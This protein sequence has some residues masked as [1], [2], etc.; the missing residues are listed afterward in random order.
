MRSRSHQ[1][2]ARSTITISDYTA[3][4]SAAATKVPDN[5]TLLE[6]RNIGRRDAAAGKWLLHDVSFQVRSG[7]RVALI[8]PSGSGKTLL[9]RA[10]AALDPVE[11]GQLLWRGQP[12]QGGIVP[13]F[14]R[15]AIYV[16]QRPALTEGSVESNLREPFSLDLH[17]ERKFDIRRIESQ[18]AK[19]G[20]DRSFLDKRQQDLSGGEMQLVALLRAIQLDPQVLLL[21][22]PTASLDSATARAVEELVTGWFSKN[23]TGRSFVW[24][25]HDGQQAQR[26]A[27]HIG[28][29]ENGMLTQER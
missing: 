9:L 19:V 8:G 11:C 13:A 23:S 2:A 12:V 21:D 14:R 10:L 18:L 28:S 1:L 16:Q 26:I 22:E 4:H 25:S 6:A 20:R 3:T 24:V 17:R 15:N 5:G 7:D 27:D 29:I